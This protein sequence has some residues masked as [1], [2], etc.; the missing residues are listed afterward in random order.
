[1]D[2]AT[3]PPSRW[4][5]VLR[6]FGALW[7]L[8]GIL[9]FALGIYDLSQR[10]GLGWFHAAIG[11]LFIIIGAY[12][13]RRSA[14]TTPQRGLAAAVMTGSIFALVVGLAGFGAV[15]FGGHIEAPWDLVPAPLIV[16]GTFGTWFGARALRSEGVGE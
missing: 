11:T 2:A 12:S 6:F 8:L 16:I 10:D 13:L 5:T 15:I 7:L 3:P 1:M 9:D 14:G 4:R